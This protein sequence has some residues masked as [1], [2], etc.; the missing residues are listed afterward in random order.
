[1]SFS[2]R[3]G[4]RAARGVAAGLV[5][6][7]CCQHCGNRSQQQCAKPIACFRSFRS[8]AVRAGR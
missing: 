6:Q 7:A 5:A 4:R 1:M 8:C 3:Q 2:F